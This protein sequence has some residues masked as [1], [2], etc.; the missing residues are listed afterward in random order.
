MFGLKSCY[1]LLL[2]LKI[3]RQMSL[4]SRNKYE[5]VCHVVP[6]LIRIQKPSYCKKSLDATIR[7]LETVPFC[8]IRTYQL[9]CVRTL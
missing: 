9:F 1:N 5:Q 7:C 3:I 6:C 4:K 2:T 8:R